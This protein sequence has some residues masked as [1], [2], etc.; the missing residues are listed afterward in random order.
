MS[1]VVMLRHVTK[2]KV[3]GLTQGGSDQTLPGLTRVTFGDITSC[4]PVLS[5][6]V[7]TCHVLRHVSHQVSSGCTQPE[8]V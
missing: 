8:V 7:Y 5:G 2:C 4:H 6:G 1:R 3:E